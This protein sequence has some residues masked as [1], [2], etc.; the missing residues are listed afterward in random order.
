MLLQ[1]EDT[2]DFLTVIRELQMSFEETSPEEFFNLVLDK[3]NYK[4]KITNEKR[5]IEKLNRINEFKEY[6]SSIPY[7]SNNKEKTMEFINN[8]YL[9]DSKDSKEDGVKLMTIHQSKGLEFKIVILVDLNEGILPTSNKTITSI[10]EERRIF[11]VGITRAK[12]R[13]FITSAE[14]HFINGRTIII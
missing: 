11:Y 13:L 8:I 14:K 12:E 5:A 2:N 9:D 3:F 1:G 7:T 6:I 4:E 10:E